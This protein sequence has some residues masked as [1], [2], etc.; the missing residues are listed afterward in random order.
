MG[1]IVNTNNVKKKAG[2]LIP[3]KKSVAHIIVDNG[4][5][6]VLVDN[7]QKFS[8]ERNDSEMLS[9]KNDIEEIR[10]GSSS[11]VQ[12]YSAEAGD[13]DYSSGSVTALGAYR[14]I[15][16]KIVFNE[17]SIYAAAPLSNYEIQ[18]RVYSSSTKPVFSN[19]P[20]ISYNLIYQG[21]RVW[22][23]DVMDIKKISTPDIEI[24][25]GQ[26]LI[27]MFATFTNLPPKFRR[28]SSDVSGRFGFIFSDYSAPNSV[29]DNMVSVADDGSSFSQAMPGLAYS[30][31]SANI[32]ELEDRVS[33]LESDKSGK[34]NPRITLPSVIYSTV[35]TETNLYYD[36]FTLGL[37]GAFSV[38]VLCG[39]GRSFERMFQ[40]E[41]I[42]DHIGDNTLTVNVYD[43]NHELIETKSIILRV[44]SDSAPD[45]DKNILLVGDSTL[46]N[47]PLTPTIYNK[48]D[49]LGSHIP[50][51]WGGKGIYPYNHQGWPGA[52]FNN[53]ATAASG[54]SRY[55]F[56]VTGASA[57]EQDSVYTNNGSSF[58]VQDIYT[59][60]GSGKIRAY[61][62]SGSNNPSASGT[63]TKSSGEGP[64]TISFSAFSVVSANP[65]WNNSTQQL[66]IAQYRSKL[67]MDS[68]KFDIVA[69]RLGINDSF[70]ELRTDVDRI[71]VIDDLKTIISAF[72]A[73]NA[74]T[75]F[76][77]ELPT[78]DGSTRSGWGVNYGATGK[79]E[80]YHLNVWRLRELIISTFDNGLYDANIE[81]CATG[82]MVDRYYGYE[83]S[84]IQSSSRITATELRH[85]NAVHPNTD[86][87]YQLADAVFPHILHLSQ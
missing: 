20:N 18:V 56:T 38:E 78:T 73:D 82:A 55:E 6:K 2:L 50:I 65:F 11:Y 4:D 13:S 36:A 22:N 43:S 80:N 37:P 48:F 51:F 62:S 76:I 27:F 10:N 61:R 57:L 19:I 54:D 47:G 86:G 40:I 44:I 69:I 77:I 59:S 29:F 34:I 46:N 12:F 14:L 17:I 53:Y 68:T 21:V 26:Y 75:K 63:L 16:E 33:A 58:V 42:S 31:E 8:V 52:T 84:D 45:G 81:V 79:R 49:S 35:G 66:D 72:V 67:F 24:S 3:D 74:N 83:L 15:P 9:I 41:P 25:A 70:G 32:K 39:I 7:K 5:I 28:Y 23:D 60:G 30:S 64:S 1:K 85:T 71:G 87:Y